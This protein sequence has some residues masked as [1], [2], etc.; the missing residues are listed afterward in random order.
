VPPGSNLEE[1][2]QV[3][4]SINSP[5]AAGTS[6]ENTTGIS[7]TAPT[8]TTATPSTTP[9]GIGFSGTEYSTNSNCSE[10]DPIALGRG[11][12]QCKAAREASR[13]SD[14]TE[15]TPGVDFGKKVEIK[16]ERVGNIN[17]ASDADLYRTFRGCRVSSKGSE[18][19]QVITASFDPATLQ[20]VT[21]EKEHGI[22]PEDGTELVIIVGDQNFP[23]CLSGKNGCVPV[24][25][26][27]DPSLME[28][29][30]I[31][32]E[33]FDRYPMPA[34][35]LFLV[36]STSHLQEMG[37]T[38]YALDWVRVCKEF[39]GRWK[40]VKVGPLPPVLRE[41]TGPEITRLLTE[42]W[43]WY[44]CVYGSDICYPRAAWDTAIK[45]LGDNTE[46]VLDLAGRDTYT[47]ALPLSLK[48]TA[49]THHKFVS[50]ASLPTTLAFSGEAT[51]A[52][53]HALLYQLNTK[54]GCRAHPEDILAREPAEQEGAMETSD[55]NTPKIIIC[56]GSICKRMAQELQDMGLE[57]ID[58][59]KPGWTPTSENISRLTT[60]IAAATPGKNSIIEGTCCPTP[61]FALS[62]STVTMPCL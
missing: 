27:E 46:Q 24:V 50:S 57:V 6:G 29:F 47:V 39:T 45:H 31:S 3:N 36:G 28:L 53:L 49:L 35:T 61:V 22:I 59:T 21:C 55:T 44:N 1:T 14:G 38:I 51:R 5:P 10:Y 8:P 23:S 52:L 2:T 62:R 48:S 26:L 54:F 42:V 25:R 19:N 33:I 37:S 7:A 9:S 4:N 12:R 15:T 34:G 17:L 30:D 56:G 13:K 11:Y 18:V 16:A 41:Q 60:D 58:L 20:C 43:R 32:L 40:H